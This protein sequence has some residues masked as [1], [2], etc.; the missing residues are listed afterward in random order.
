MNMY[1]VYVYIINKY[2]YTVVYISSS[3]NVLYIHTY[4]KSSFSM[5]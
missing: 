3:N 2:M 4:G 5:S 1:T